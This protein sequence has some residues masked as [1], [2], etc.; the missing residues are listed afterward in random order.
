MTTSQLLLSAWHWHPSVLLG[1]AVLIAGYL[2]ALEFRPP[3][4]ALTYL[5]GV[6]VLLVA[7]ISPIH[8][9]GDQYLFSA[10]MLQHL[11]LVQAVP[12]LLL[13]GIPASLA[14]Q[15]LGLPAGESEPTT[16]D[17]RHPRQE[18]PDMRQETRDGSLRSPVS[19]LQP[20]ASSLRPP[21]SGLQ[22]PTR[23]TQ[24][25]T[26]N[27]LFI[28][29]RSSF[30][31]LRQVGRSVLV[32]AEQVLSQPHIAWLIGMGAMWVWHLPAFYNATLTYQS[33]H[34]V[35]HLCFLATAT[36]FWWP[37]VGPLAERR[38][39]P[40]VAALYLF[41]AMLASSVLGILLTFAPPGLYPAYLHPADTL[42]ILPLLRQQWGLS[43]AA[44]Q[45]LGGLLMW[46]PGSLVYLGALI[47]TLARWY[48]APEEDAMSA[49]TSGEVREP[50]SVPHEPRRSHVA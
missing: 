5:A 10:H 21:A 40:L 8:A 43:P 19:C 25:A 2:A 35:E 32:A 27:T 39:A 4:A 7:L 14:R 38:L 11:L 15:A 3:R 13:L 26:R 12:P 46:V 49:A 6:L 44:D 31:N 37:I 17:R 33:I 30:V 18:M 28:V 50:P 22:H 1:C 20:P 47:A 34:I 42:G 9:L 29:H 45:Q 24:Y 41:A 48:C 23:N 36:I 16:S